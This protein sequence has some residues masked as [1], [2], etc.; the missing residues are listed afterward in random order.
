MRLSGVYVQ[1][2]RLSGGECGRCDVGA[3]N[4]RSRDVMLSGSET[5]RSRQTTELEVTE[6]LRC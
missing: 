4:R 6:M 5:L 1:Q 2:S 3:Q